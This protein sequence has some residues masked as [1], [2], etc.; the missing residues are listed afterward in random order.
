MVRKNSDLR[1][2]IHSAGLK[3]WQ[4]ASELGR[5]EEWLVKK[6]RHDL[7]DETRVSILEAIIKLREAN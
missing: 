2:K 1:E 4:I 5:S 6:L 3:Q 7:G